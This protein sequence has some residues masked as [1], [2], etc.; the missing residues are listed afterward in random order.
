MEQ[1]IDPV[2]IEECKRLSFNDAGFPEVIQRLG[3]TGVERYTA[4]LVRLEKTYYGIAGDSTADALPLEDPPAIG[5]D[6]V[7]AEVRQAIASSQRREIGYAEFLRRVMAAGTAS[8]M[9]FLN[10][11]RA[12]YFGRNGD[13]HVERFLGEP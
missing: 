8:Y 4:D 7:E 6:F 12:I 3:A 2:V 9:V 1:R 5:G 11:R 13:F 10:G